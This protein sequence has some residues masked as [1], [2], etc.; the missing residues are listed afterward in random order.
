MEEKN[1]GGTPSIYGIT[2]R[3]TVRA[4]IVLATCVVVLAFGSTVRSADI[5]DAKDETI[6]VEVRG[7]RVTGDARKLL[8]VLFPHQHPTL[9]PWDS[10]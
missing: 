10:F 1:I 3:L 8:G 5:G 9:S 2:R 4:L 6:T 7:I